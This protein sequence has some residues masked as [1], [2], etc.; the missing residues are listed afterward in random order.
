MRV[1]IALGV[2]LGMCLVPTPVHAL[3]LKNV[4]P[5]TGRF[6]ATRNITEY[7]PGGC[8]YLSFQIADITVDP[9]TNDV[10]YQTTLEVFDEKNKSLLKRTSVPQEVTLSGGNELP[11]YAFT[12][13]SPD[14]PSGRYTMKV[15]V[16]DLLGKQTKSFTHK[17][18]ILSP[19]FGIVQPTGVSMGLVGQDYAL[20]F[21]L[22]GMK[23]DEKTMLPKIILT[24]QMTDLK[25]N[26]MFPKPRT[27]DV[28]KLHGPVTDLTK[29]DLIPIGL[30]F[31]LN[32]P[33]RFIISVIAEDKIGDQKAKFT[34]PLR[35]LDSEG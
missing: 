35:V 14:Q 19:A 2:M 9:K 13:L 16:K 1:L 21:G 33:G 24:V 15:T 11:S 28:E 7:L 29:K 12:F 8:V 30:P 34:F 6:G 22:V 18:R 5:T 4:R 26:K 31:F 25:G 20:S 3:K 17:F 27:I 10:K 32:R 23:K